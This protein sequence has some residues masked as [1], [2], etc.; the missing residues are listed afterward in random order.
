MAEV[1]VNLSLPW[2]YFNF[3]KLPWLRNEDRIYF[4]LV[5]INTFFYFA[6][7]RIEEDPTYKRVE[8]DGIASSFA[9]SMKD[10]LNRLR[11]DIPV[12]R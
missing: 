12:C 5:E 9:L 2:L 6:F 3:Q 11:Q 1:C 8:R 10:K 4:K 7:S